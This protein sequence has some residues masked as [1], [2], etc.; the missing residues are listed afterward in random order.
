M[1]RVYDKPKTPY[2]RILER[3]DVDP[4][5]KRKLKAIYDELNP[6]ELKRRIDDK[7]A[8]LVSLTQRKGA[9]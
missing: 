8:K 5:N 9:A 6:F 7:L 4:A 3:D 1:K 2:R